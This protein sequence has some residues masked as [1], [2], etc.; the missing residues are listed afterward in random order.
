MKNSILMIIKWIEHEWIELKMNEWTENEWN[1]MND[2]FLNV[3][4]GVNRITIKT[5]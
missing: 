2:V 4:V 5:F 1:K 3:C